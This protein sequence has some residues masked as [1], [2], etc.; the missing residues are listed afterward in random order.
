MIELAPETQ[1]LNYCT[2]DEALMHMF[3][4]KG[5]R[6][7]TQK[8]LAQMRKL[9]NKETILIWTDDTI[10]DPQFKMFELGPKHTETLKF[11][12]RLI[13]VRDVC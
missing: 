3:F 9:L 2:Q 6:L 13:L 5:Y 1:W 4:Q 10:H 12:A 11:K 8:E 7:P